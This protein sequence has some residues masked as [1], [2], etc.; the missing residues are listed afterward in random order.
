[1]FEPKRS[2]GFWKIANMK[3]LDRLKNQVRFIH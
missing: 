2:K 1:M 3:E